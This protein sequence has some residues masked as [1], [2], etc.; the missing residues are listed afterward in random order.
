[1]S[2]KDRECNCCGEPLFDQ[3]P[4]EM[5]NLCDDCLKLEE[6]EEF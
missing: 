2:K 3:D 4:D 1:M 5:T 6:A